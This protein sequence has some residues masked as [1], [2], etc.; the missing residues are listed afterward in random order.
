MLTVLER[1]V[2]AVGVTILVLVVLRRV[3]IVERAV[4]ERRG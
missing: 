3:S 2:P 1:W 4:W